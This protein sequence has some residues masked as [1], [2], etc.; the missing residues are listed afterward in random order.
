MAD[1]RVHDVRFDDFSVI[2][3]LMDGR[4]IAAPLAWFPRLWNASAD[5]RAVWERCAGG[6]GIHWPTLDEDLSTHSLLRLVLSSK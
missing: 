2:V 6:Y 4:S 3:E 1:E 5:Q